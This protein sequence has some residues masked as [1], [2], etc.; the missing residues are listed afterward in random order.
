MPSK[1]DGWL[2]IDDDDNDKYFQLRHIDA[3][4]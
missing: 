4:D 2:Q 3:Y 1:M